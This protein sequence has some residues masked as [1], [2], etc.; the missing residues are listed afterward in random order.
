MAVKTATRVDPFDSPQQRL[1]A[2]VMG[3]W[4]FIVAVVMIFGACILGYLVVRL[5][6]PPGQMWRPEGAPGLPHALLI[7]TGVLLTSSWT[8]QL[9]VRAARQGQRALLHAALGWTLTLAGL[10]LAT[11]TV[12]WVELWRQHAT[13]ESSLYAWTFYVLTG[14]HALHVLGGIPPL[15]VVFRRSAQGRYTPMEHAGVVYCA[16][17]WHTLDAIWLALYATLW[18]GGG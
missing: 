10:F 14:V 5:D 7:S 6:R 2:G 12:A 17:Y 9:A 11:Q 15:W 3:M 16:M 13:I 1:Q 18:L 8:V 4:W